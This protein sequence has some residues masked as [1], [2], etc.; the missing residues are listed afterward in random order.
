MLEEQK[1]KEVLR[2]I[3]VPFEAADEGLKQ[4][5]AT[6]YDMLEKEAVS[7]WLYRVFELERKED[8]IHFKH[9]TMYSKSKDLSK[10]LATSDR[11]YI[12]AVTLGIGVDRLIHSMQLKDMSQALLLDACANTMIEAICDGIACTIAKEE[13]YPVHLTMR[14]SPGYGDVS[15]EEQ[16][17]LLDLLNAE[18]QIGLGVSKSQMLLPTKSVTA[19]IGVSAQKQVIKE[20][21]D[22]CTLSATCQ[23]RK[24]GESCGN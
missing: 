13:K 12:L 7:R 24:R 4:Q 6:C 9:T 23:Y 19:F 8:T 2:Y 1:L 14:Y 20:T 18:K 15:L 21:C 3:Q 11:C 22:T 17:K 16:Q 10:L 5:I